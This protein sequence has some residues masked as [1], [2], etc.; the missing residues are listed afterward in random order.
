MLKKLPRAARKSKI[1]AK[2]KAK[3]SKKGKTLSKG[4]L[5]T[6]EALLAFVAENPTRNG[7]RE[8][9]KA[10]GVTGDARVGLKTLLY[11]F[12][13]TILDNEEYSICKG[14]KIIF[15]VFRA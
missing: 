4:E 9:A 7:K 11:P 5:P 2:K 6:R 10:F 3:A 15:K 14:C 1:V 8:I 13:T 12:L